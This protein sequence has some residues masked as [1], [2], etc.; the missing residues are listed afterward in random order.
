MEKSKKQL[1]GEI[2]AAVAKSAV[3]VGPPVA[4]AII[5]DKMFGHHINTFEPLYFKL[6]D[7]PGLKREKHVFTS[8]QGQKLVGYLY[9][10]DGIE[11]NA[12]VVLSHGYGGGGQ[13]TYMDC[14][15]Y[16]T[17]NGFYVF[18][19]D[20][21][22]NDESEGNDI[23]GFPQ[24]IIDLDH[25]IKYIT[26]LKAYMDYPLFLFGHSW[27]GYNVCNALKD[28][29]NVKAVV[30]LS[31][32]NNAS[33]LIKIRGE[34]YGGNSAETISPYIESQNKAR[35]GKY[36]D[37]SAMDAFAHSKAPVFIIHSGDDQVVPYIAGYKIYY[38]K[39]K[40]DSRFKFLLYE[41]RGHGTV[42]YN[43]EAVKYT[44]EFE[45][46]LNKFEKGKHSEEEKIAFINENIDRN[47]WANRIDKK[48]FKQIIEFYK[49][50]I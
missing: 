1:F 45:K 34:G 12:L 18:A 50:N 11:K 26:G 39:Y 21:T 41:N 37:Y 7:F 23:G 28:N 24:G 17:L 40:N 22:A 15:N 5:F 20:A 29:P 48:L 16:L 46:K 43:D 2:A 35:F 19:Y 6:E 4:A 44:R 31:G 30:E 8:D 33:D 9:Y 32:F 47:F 13:R 49:S 42:Y 3:I 10:R 25:A 27:G 36:G 14:T 38:D